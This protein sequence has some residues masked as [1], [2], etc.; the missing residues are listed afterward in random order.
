MVNCKRRKHLLSF[1]MKIIFEISICL[2]LLF[3]QISCSSEEK[4]SQTTGSDYK[5]FVISQL[6]GEI[7]NS[8]SLA[9]KVV[10]VDYWATW[11]APCIKEVPGYNDLYE[12][13]KDEN[14]V[15]LAICMDSGNAEKIE[16]FLNEFLIKYP[17]YVGNS[18]VRAAFG[19]IPAYP[20][21]FVLDQMGKIQKQYIG[22]SS[23]KIEEIDGV[24]AGLL[25][26]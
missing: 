19:D 21:T 10:L 25:Q 2:T 18:E 6:N 1:I 26:D 23:T 7:L 15:F 12:K 4:K 5:P 14:F 8:D 3:S 17:V 20:T 24:I 16:P 9:G 11:C 13:Y 22:I